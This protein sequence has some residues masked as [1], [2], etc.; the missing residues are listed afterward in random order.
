VKFVKHL[1]DRRQAIKFG[2]LW[3]ICVFLFTFLLASKYGFTD[4]TDLHF[5]SRVICLR[6]LYLFPST[7][8]FIL[9]N[10]TNMSSYDGLFTYV[11]TVIY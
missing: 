7:N 4:I 2:Y 6:F 9:C 5:L 1:K 3:H 8:A 11:D 10:N